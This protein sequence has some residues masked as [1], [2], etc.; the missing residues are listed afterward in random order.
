MLYIPDSQQ[1]E[2]QMKQCIVL[3]GYVNHKSIGEQL[4]ITSNRFIQLNLYGS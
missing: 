1:I 4:H 2:Q 3:F